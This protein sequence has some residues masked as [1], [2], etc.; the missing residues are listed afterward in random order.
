MGELSTSGWLF[1]ILA[2]GGIIL[3]NVFCFGRLFRESEGKMVS[4]LE[5]ES[6]IDR[7]EDEKE[8]PPTSIPPKN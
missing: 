2:W 3:F 4:P 7:I 8:H 1:M 5:I 6:E